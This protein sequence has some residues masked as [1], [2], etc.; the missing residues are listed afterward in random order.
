MDNLFKLP[1]INYSILDTGP[2]HTVPIAWA[3]VTHKIFIEKG[4][5]LVGLDQNMHT[6]EII[7]MGISKT[8]Y[9]IKRMLRME[10]KG[11]IYWVERIDCEPISQFNS[12]DAPKGSKV[13]IVNRQSFKQQIDLI[14]EE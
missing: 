13:R 7:E 11:R 3:K 8:K 2:V 6:G 14:F 1:G 5:K 4:K 12:D 9:R 10:A